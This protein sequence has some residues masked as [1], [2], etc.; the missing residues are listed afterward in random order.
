MLQGDSG[1]G[2][3]CATDHGS[4]EVQGISSFT[5]HLCAVKNRPAIFTKV[6]RYL[7]WIAK[8]MKSEA[9]NDNTAA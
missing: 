4:Y 3:V 1:G 7:S 6:D 5:G 2:L 8:I 9:K